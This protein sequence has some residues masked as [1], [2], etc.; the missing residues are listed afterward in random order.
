MFATNTPPNPRVQR[1]RVA[2]CARPGSPLTRHPFEDEDSTDSTTARLLT[3]AALTEECVDHP[4]AGAGPADCVTEGRICTGD[5]FPGGRSSVTAD[6]MPDDITVDNLDTSYF[7]QIE[8]PTG[9]SAMRIGGVV[10]GYVLEVSPPPATATFNSMRRPIIG[11]SSSSRRSRNR[12]SR[13][14]VMPRPRSF[15]PDDP[16]TRGQMAAFLAKALGLQWP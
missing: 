9:G 8:Q 5:D 12:A 15:C 4:A 6:L 14:A 3:C 13:A 2:R 16:L 11:S 10:V 1:T 7:L